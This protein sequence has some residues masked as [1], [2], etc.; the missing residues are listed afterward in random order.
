M[1]IDP[2]FYGGTLR[3][4]FVATATRDDQAA[5]QRLSSLVDGHDDLAAQ[6]E[7]AWSVLSTAIRWAARA[8]EHAGVSGTDDTPIRDSEAAFARAQHLERQLFALGPAARLPRPRSAARRTRSSTR[9]T[10]RPSS[11]RSRADGSPRSAES[12]IRSSRL[13]PTCRRSATTP[14]RR[15][16]ASTSSASA[17]SSPKPPRPWRPR[18]SVNT[19][20][21]RGSRR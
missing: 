3:D 1:A 14:A 19:M 5:A 15:C 17:T 16:T 9:A 10:P 13:P 21:P 18:P 20:A 6:R 7:D 2:I 8:L 12:R 11:A 4:R